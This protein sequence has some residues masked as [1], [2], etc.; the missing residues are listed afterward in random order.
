MT[1]MLWRRR[2]RNGEL[3]AYNRSVSPDRAT[4]HSSPP[5]GGGQARVR[6]P[7]GHFPFARTISLDRLAG[8]L[9][10]EPL[11]QLRD[12]VGIHVELVTGAQVRQRFGR[13][14]R[15]ATQ[16]YKLG[17]K[18]LEPGRRDE[19][20]DPRRLVALVPESVRTGAP[21][22]HGDI[23]PI[24]EVTGKRFGT[25]MIAVIANDGHLEWELY[26]GKFNQH[27]FIGFLGRL[28]CHHPDRRIHLGS[29]LL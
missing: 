8:K 26:D 6:R 5:L 11:D 1:G 4:H 17:E 25:N 23:T 29:S 10:T 20:K 16:P 9:H 3:L 14:I 13:R 27:V 7:R 19:L 15:D 22:A 18:P 2:R 21:T 28:L 24:K 12:T